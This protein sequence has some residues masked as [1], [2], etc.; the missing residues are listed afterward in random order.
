MAVCCLLV[1]M[2]YLLGRVLVFESGLL[3]M[4]LTVGFG[5][6][7]LFVFVGL[8]DAGASIPHDCLILLV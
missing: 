2:R 4:A 5:I 1:S 3:A 7:L 8:A 6:E